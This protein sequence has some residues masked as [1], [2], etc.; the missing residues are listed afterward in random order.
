MKAKQALTERFGGLND[1][2]MWSDDTFDARI[3]EH[4]FK[5]V[6]V[7]N[8]RNSAIDSEGENL[9]QQAMNEHPRLF[10]GPILD[11]KSATSSGIE[12]RV[13]DYKEFFVDRLRGGRNVKPLGVSG[14]LLKDRKILVG[15]RPPTVTQYQGFVE[16][17]PSGSVEYCCGCDEVDPVDTLY[18]ELEEELGIG[19][20]GVQVSP[21]PILVFDRG[22]ATFDICFQI[23]SSK[24]LKQI[25][26]AEKEW[27]SHT[28][29][30]FASV[31]E[32]LAAKTEVVPTT[33]AICHLMQKELLSASA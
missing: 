4:G 15:K 8:S 9:W 29:V 19:S 23:F 20:D 30:W 5:V 31:P 22:G 11:V 3:F 26:N 10:N 32:L 1:F 12:V 25:E 28:R 21:N 17:L 33:L 16:S 27:D 18:H 2:A 13:I 7:A 24:T 6:V 14:F